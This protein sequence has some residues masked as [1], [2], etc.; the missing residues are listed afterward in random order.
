MPRKS[1]SSYP[2][3]WPEIAFR[4]KQEA[5]WRCIRC[6]H[7]NDWHNGYA[8]TVHHL[9]MD[10]QNCAW[11]FEHSE[12]FKPYVAGYYANLYHLPTDRK[13]VME[14]LDILLNIGRHHLY[15]VIPAGQA[16]AEPA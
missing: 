2:A 7:L 11:M 1:K 12:W 8:L 3:D 14:H 16:A 10:P 5:G 6:F 4:V 15:F 13:W 9:D